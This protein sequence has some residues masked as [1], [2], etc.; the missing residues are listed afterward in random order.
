MRT[1]ILFFASMAALAAQ[2]TV[3]PT[4]DQAGPAR[5]ENWS[6]YNIVN[7]FETGY[8]FAGVAGNRDEYS[9]M[10]NYRDGV[11]LLGSFFSM[12][13]KD[14]HGRFFDEIVLTTEGLGNDPY[15]SAVLRIRKNRIYRYDMSWRQNDYLNPGL[16]SSGSG[17]QHL[18][19][20]VYRMQDHDLTLF[21]ESNLKF[22]L[23]Y[24]ETNQTGPAFSSVQLFNA[25][26]PVYP[27][28]SDVRRFQH[29]YRIGNE[30]RLFGIRVNWM[31]GWQ[32]FKEDSG[33]ALTNSGIAV[34][35]P[36]A[37][38]LTSFQRTEPYHGT[39]PYWR[40]ALFAERSWLSLNGRFT[41]T[42]GNRGFVVDESAIGPGRFGV[43]QNQ[44]IVTFGNAQRPVST[45][46]LNLSF[47]P[48]KKLTITSST[49]LYNVRTSG[50]SVFSQ[51]NDATLQ[52]ASVS[53]Q[54]LGM[55]TAATEAQ[56]DYEFSPKFG[57]FAG[58]EYSNRRIR[59]IEEVS[60]AGSPSLVAADQT[61]QLNLGRMG[62]H[63]RPIKPLSILFSGEVGRNDNPF[64]PVSLR[65]YH[66]LNGRIQYRTKAITASGGVSTVYN[67]NSIS[68]T[69]FSSQSRRYF[70]DVA[71]NAKPWLSFDASVSRLHLYSI[72]GI[73]YFA[74][75]QLVTGEDSIYLSN[76][77][78][79]VFGARFAIKNRADL[80]VAYSRVQ[81]VGDGRST[82]VDGGIGSALPLFQAAQTFPV[83]FQSPFA[84]LSVR[85]N[86]RMRWNVGYQY[87]GYR[88]RFYRGQDYIANT[89]YS[90]ISWS[91]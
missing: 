36:A 70:G 51:F 16:V 7:S 8:R 11:R 38:P 64:T 46:N 59:S 23:G 91:F 63:F 1:A 75:A 42:S 66:A 78:S 28:F 35:N 37:A 43:Q 74:N 19:D 62:F 76:I 88:E 18:L 60:V 56:I 80:Y 41:Y 52:T 77:N 71:W 85:L 9:S 33:F 26:G 87:Y 27:L 5:G 57:A 55:K 72:G 10:V 40:A 4:P 67:V 89:G 61:N 47:F 12:N 44:Q 58:Y 53:F 22:F 48:T 83:M 50:N 79:V 13:S 86:A 73:A 81:D 49:S 21:P 39:S 84:R 3:A 31:H 69:A 82:P 17:G 6:G 65:N 15:Q 30:F 14:G 45:G 34:D 29:E 2:E 32:D 24:S 25:A 54:Y 20:T 90:S 68:L